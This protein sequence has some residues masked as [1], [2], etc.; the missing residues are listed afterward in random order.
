MQHH[1]GQ[2]ILSQAFVQIADAHTV[3]FHL[4]AD[5]VTIDL[6]QTSLADST[7][8][9]VEDL[10][11]QI[12]YENRSVTAR[13]VDP[14]DTCGVRLRK[15]PEHLHTAGLRIIDIDGF[16]V[17]ACGGTH[18]ARTGEIGIIKV[19]RLEKRG[20]KTRVEFRC[21]KRALQ[22]YRL[23]NALIYQLTAAFTCAMDEL[24]QSVQRLQDNLKTLQS[25]LKAANQQLLD[26][27]AAQLLSEASEHNG[28]KLIKIA[29]AERDAGDLRLLASRL[30]Q[31]P[32]V[33]ALLG[34]SGE[35]ANLVFA[36]SADL[37]DDMNALLKQT[38]T[39][40]KNGRGGGQPAMAQGSGMADAPQLQ[41]ALDEAAKTVAANHS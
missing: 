32:G 14:A 13:L 5:T 29:F 28:V 20:D 31:S 11:N 1:T 10:A 33:I 18:V 36:R 19:M 35:R 38:L 41:A 9:E 2:H 27:E 24:P 26:Y 40:I 30:A 23:K 39:L 6:N 22:D 25:D 3:G 7:V 8:A 37:S 21:G 17:T 34:T 4:S 12:V 15:L 16:D